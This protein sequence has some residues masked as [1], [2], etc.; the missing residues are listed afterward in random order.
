MENTKMSLTGFKTRLD[1]LV[2]HVKM[3]ESYKD[4][5]PYGKAVPRDIED[6]NGAFKKQ[7]DY[8][9]YLESE[10][11]KLKKPVH[12]YYVMNGYKTIDGP[13]YVAVMATDEEAAVNLAREEYKEESKNWNEGS[14]FYESL[15]AELIEEAKISKEMVVGSY[16]GY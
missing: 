14:D 6:L 8:I 5:S 16:Y 13:V 12:L 1:M 7:H 2:H 15:R 4:R 3:N 10:L 11:E 9:Q